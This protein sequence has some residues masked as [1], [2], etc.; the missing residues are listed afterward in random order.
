MLRTRRGGVESFDEILQ[1][2]K[3]LWE[4]RYLWIITHDD[5]DEH[6]SRCFEAE[7]ISNQ[8]RWTHNYEWFGIGQ[9]LINPKEPNIIEYCLASTMR[10][11]NSIFLC[12]AS[13]F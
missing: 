6:M 1:I 4:G 3:S 2:L 7:T 9:C 12:P 5:G 13:A 11:S 8:L 10:F